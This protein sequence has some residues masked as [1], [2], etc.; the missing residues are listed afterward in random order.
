MEKIKMKRRQ[1]IV[2]LVIDGSEANRALTISFMPLFLEIILRGLKAL[3]AL[4]AFT[5]D[6]LLAI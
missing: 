1:T 6:K 2:T 5:D 3:K 4:S